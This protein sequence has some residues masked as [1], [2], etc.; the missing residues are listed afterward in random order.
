MTG[1]G[2]VYWGQI[3]SVLGSLV[4]GGSIATQWTAA[5]LGYQSQLG[6]ADAVAWGY[7][8]TDGLALLPSMLPIHAHNAK[9]QLFDLTHHH[10]MI[11]ASPKP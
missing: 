6:P 3:A 9:L 2:R 7:A 1:A 8:P 10:Q 11:G 4:L 5:E